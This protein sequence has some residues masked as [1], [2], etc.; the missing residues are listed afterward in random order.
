MQELTVNLTLHSTKGEKNVFKLSST[1]GDF[2][3]MSLLFSCYHWRK[4][5][6]NNNNL[7]VAVLPFSLA[8]ATGFSGGLPSKNLD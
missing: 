8:R 3:D 4:D 7:Q 6:N 2:I 1:P 5:N